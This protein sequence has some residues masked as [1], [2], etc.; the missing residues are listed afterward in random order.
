MPKKCLPKINTP[1]STNTSH[2]I[3]LQAPDLKYWTLFPVHLPPVHPSTIISAL[4]FTTSIRGD[5]PS[6][7]K[8][9][10]DMKEKAGT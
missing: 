3:N 2:E 6:I 7:K 4:K 1:L 9:L 8:L 5:K 10:I